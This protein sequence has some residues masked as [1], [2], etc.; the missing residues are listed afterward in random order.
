MTTVGAPATEVI[1]EIVEEFLSRRPQLGSVRLLLIDGR[2]GSGKTTLATPL[3]ASLAA[4][5]VHLE[6][7]YPGWDGLRDGVLL[8]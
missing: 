6:Y 7:L 5:I 8:A 2:T 1:D 3:S 4:P